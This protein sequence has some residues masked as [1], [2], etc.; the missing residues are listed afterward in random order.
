MSGPDGAARGLARSTPR[1]SFPRVVRA[2][3]G[4]ANSGYPTL[5]IPEGI[6]SG[7]V[8]VLFTNGLYQTYSASGW[9]TLEASNGS[10]MTCGMFKRIATAGDSGSTVTVSMSGSADWTAQ[11][12]VVRPYGDYTELYDTVQA[13]SGGDIS[14]ATLTPTVGS[15]A[16]AF[17]GYRKSGTASMSISPGRYLHGEAFSAET[18]SMGASTRVPAGGYQALAHVVSGSTSG[19][20]AGLYVMSP[21]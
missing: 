4:G 19:K 8:M 20:G 10:Y 1:V 3:S 17:G 6:A 7:D 21:A 16:L 2:V 15:L 9:T 14:T 5:T 13:G 12:L 18:M 11:L